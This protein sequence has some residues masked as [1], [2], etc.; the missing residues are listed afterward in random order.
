MP[1]IFLTLFAGCWL[2]R[3]GSGSS[4]EVPEGPE[5]HACYFDNSFYAYL[6]KGLKEP[7]PPSGSPVY[8][9]DAT[10][11]SDTNDGLSSSTPWKTLGKV[12]QQTFSPGSCI[13][14]KRGEQ[15]IGERLI[16]PSSGSSS[17]PISFG[18]YGEGA[19]PI[20]SAA[21]PVP[22][23]SDPSSWTEQGSNLWYLTVDSDPGRSPKRIW[24]SHVEYM[25]AQSIATVNPTYRWYYDNTTS[26]LYVYAE[27]NPASYYTSI[28][29]G[30][31]ED[32]AVLIAGVSHIILQNLD[33]RGGRAASIGV[34]GASNVILEGLVVGKYAD[35]HGIEIS[36]KNWGGD[37]HRESSHCIIRW[38]VIDSGHRLMY[39]YDKPYPEDGI[40]LSNGANSIEIYENQI[41]NWGHTA[42]NL[43]ATNLFTTVNSNRIYS[44]LITAKEVGYCRGFGSLG[45]EDRCRDNEF[46]YNIIRDT[47]VRNQLGGNHNVFKYNIIDTL[48]N[49]PYKSYGTAQGIMITHVGYDQQYVC[50]DNTVLNNIFYN[51]DEAGIEITNYNDDFPVK[52]NTVAKNLVIQAGLQPKEGPKGVSFR[53]KN[54]DQISGNSIIENVF[55]TVGG[56]FVDYRGTLLQEGQFSGWNSSAADTIEK[57]DAYDPFF[58][59][60]GGHNFEFQS[61]SPCNK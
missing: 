7:E 48:R 43:S 11:G 38:C 24:L 18:A 4:P 42:I 17:A 22:N 59:D 51:L 27:S 13:L 33:I 3:N 15:W 40:L 50:H 47:T 32:T 10:Q 19:K 1:T 12:N 36:E 20:I 55:H 28:L 54:S 8:Y 57:N 46:F 5:E 61:T 58:L 6:Y 45:L 23:S 37:T 30:G 35:T 34:Y 44:N 16:V 25:K 21:G 2:H 41:A 53:V 52:N 39:T 9:M 49:S 60:P 56:T 31:L 29:Q 26:R 14:F